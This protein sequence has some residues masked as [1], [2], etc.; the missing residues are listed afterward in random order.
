MNKFYIY[1]HINKTNGNVF[2]VG[3][4]CKN[5]A[6]QARSRNSHWK[7]VVNKYGYEVC[8]VEDNLTNEEACLKEIRLISFYGLNNLTNMT[9]GGDGCHGF[10]DEVR[11]RIS[12]SLK[13]KVQSKESREKRSISLKKTWQSQEL[14]ELKRRQTTELIAKGI[15]SV[16][17]RPNKNKGKPFIG[18]RVKLSNSLKKYYENATAWNRADI[19]INIVNDIISE[20]KLGKSELSLSKK[21]NLNRK[22][23]HRLLL[24]NNIQIHDRRTLIEKEVLFDL[25]INKGLKRI[26]CAKELNCSEANIDKLCRIYKIRKHDYLTTS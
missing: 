15:L 13:G 26:E 25:Y 21:H 4:G 24:E 14:R 12:N 23:V 9:I 5:R 11:Q 3:K 1:L 22:V 2:Y 7:N 6:Y 17:G 20:Y 10:K 16:K 18:D 8:I 19:D